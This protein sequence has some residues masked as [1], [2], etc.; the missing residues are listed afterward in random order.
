MASTFEITG[1]KETLD[2]FQ[3]LAKE[4][5][6]KQASSK[7]LRPAL[8]QAMRPVLQ[9]AKDSVRQDTGSLQDSLIIYV[10]RPS[11]RDRKSRYVT[12][13][14]TIIAAVVTKPIPKKVKKGYREARKQDDMLTKKKYY[15]QKGYFW[16]ARAI[17]NEFGTKKVA[18]KP[19]LRPALESNVQVVT[20][21]LSSFL[22]VKMEQ[23]RSKTR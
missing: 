6:D 7:I 3:D 10:K 12:K 4:I 17:A 22:R 20:D 16:D 19:F 14:D 5:G 1:L 9:M 18:P 8:L 23:Y 2:V 13:T 15:E 11:A 21:A